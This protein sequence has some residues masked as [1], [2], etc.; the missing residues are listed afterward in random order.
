MRRVTL[1]VVGILIAAA[2]WAGEA[3][4]KKVPFKLGAWT[5][6]QYKN[7]PVELHRIRVVEQTGSFTKSNLFRPVSSEYLETVQIQLEYSNAASKD[8]KVFLQVEWVDADGT[9]IDGYHDDESLDD[10]ETHDLVTVT[11]ST[12]K[13]GLKRAARLNVRLEVAPD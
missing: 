4:E 3:V 13:Y 1:C 10:G 12:L 2:A 5:D 7:G 6:L 11:L 8:W 9:V